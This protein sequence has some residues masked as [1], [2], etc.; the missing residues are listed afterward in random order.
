MRMVRI[1]DSDRQQIAKY[2]N[3]LLKRYSMFG[4]VMAS[5][6]RMPFELHNNRLQQPHAGSR[7]RPVVERPDTLLVLNRMSR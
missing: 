2:G 5:F 6:L 1:V 7:R 4:E 3:R